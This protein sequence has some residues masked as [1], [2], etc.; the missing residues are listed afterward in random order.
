MPG[1]TYIISPEF[2]PQLSKLIGITVDDNPSNEKKTQILSKLIDLHSNKNILSKI[3]TAGL[4]YQRYI[5]DIRLYIGEANWIL[6]QDAKEPTNK[7]LRSLNMNINIKEYLTIKGSNQNTKFREDIKITP[8][9]LQEIYNDF[10]EKLEARIKNEGK[11]YKKFMDFLKDAVPKN[12]SQE[13][14]SNNTLNHVRHRIITLFSPLNKKNTI[15]EAQ[16]DLDEWVENASR[17]FFELEEN[18][19]ASKN[20]PTKKIK[21][22][23]GEAQISFKDNTQS[24]SE[25]NYFFDDQQ[26]LKQGLN[27][28]SLTNYNSLEFFNSG[29]F[30]KH[31]KLNQPSL[32]FVINQNQF[33]PDYKYG[34]NAFPQTSESNQLPNFNDIQLTSAL[35]LSYQFSQ[36]QNSYNQLKQEL[37]D[38]LLTIQKPND[39]TPKTGDLSNFFSNGMNSSKEKQSK[40]QSVSPDAGNLN[41]SHF[42][43]KTDFINPSVANNLNHFFRSKNNTS[44]LRITPPTRDSKESDINQKNSASNIQPDENDFPEIEFDSIPQGRFSY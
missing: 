44:N 23:T 17:K 26:T 35:P 4:N 20:F 39:R 13:T 16:L 25:A 31:D 28:I 15:K 6:I 7:F 32:P 38:N 2:Y 27:K 33:L 19:I 42:D 5:D 37:N 14:I 12:E 41:F 18:S 9:E 29:N 8:N 1:K 11:F 21:L 30:V 36:L 24:N 43:Y 3:E 22:T 40:Q 10:Q 34:S